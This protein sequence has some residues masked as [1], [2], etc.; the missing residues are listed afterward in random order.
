MAK[1]TPTPKP[2]K[3]CK[4]CVQYA[5]AI[6]GEGF[7]SGPPVPTCHLS[8]MIDV[9]DGAEFFPP[10]EQMRHP[11]APCGPQAKYFQPRPVIVGDG[12]N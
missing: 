5:P 12:D 8:A 7:T 1:E 4:D 2:P 10:C 9:V 6:T 11:Q 3:F